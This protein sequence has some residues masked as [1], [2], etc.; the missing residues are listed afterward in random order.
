MSVRVLRVACD[1]TGEYRSVQQAV[2]AVPLGN[3][4]RT[5]I[6]I[7][8]GVYREPVYIPKTKNFIT[9]AALKPESTT[10]SWDNTATRIQHRQVNY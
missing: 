1:C 4:V 10:I 8:A 9:F 2:D 6:Q 5:V 3:R 7:S